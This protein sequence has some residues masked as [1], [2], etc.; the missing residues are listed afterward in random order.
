MKR[1]VCNRTGCRNVEKVKCMERK[2]SSQSS[3]KCQALIFGI[4]TTYR[5]QL[6]AIQLIAAQLIATQLIAVPKLSR[7]KLSRSNLSPSNYLLTN[8]SHD[9]YAKGYKCAFLYRNVS[10]KHNHDSAGD[11]IFNA[12][13]VNCKTL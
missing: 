11:I 6:I 13:I 7:P 1:E 4:R 10:L 2:E 3:W 9:L 8:S 12:Y 5:V